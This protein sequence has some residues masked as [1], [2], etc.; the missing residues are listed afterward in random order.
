MGTKFKTKDGQTWEVEVTAG[1][2]KSLRKECG[3]DLRDA[4]SDDG[5]TLRDALG[6]PDKFGQL[7]WTLCGKQ[8]E[9]KGLTPEDFADLFN[10]AAHRDACAAVVEEV[11]DFF[12]SPEAAKKVGAAFRQGMTAI[13]GRVNDALDHAMPSLISKLSAAN[14]EEPPGLTTVPTPSPN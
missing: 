7:I 6:D 9:A 10:G 12:Q 14:S 11:V 1:R 5:G 8:A 13:Q 4:L 2:L 3:I